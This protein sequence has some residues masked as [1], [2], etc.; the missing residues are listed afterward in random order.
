MRIIP[1]YIALGIFVTLIIL[2]FISPQPKVL[3]VTPNVNEKMSQLY[4]DDHD[5]CYRYKREEVNCQV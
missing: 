1:A 5:V 4:Q 2:Y 3:L